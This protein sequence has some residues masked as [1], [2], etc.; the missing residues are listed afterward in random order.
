MPTLVEDKLE[1]PRA[2]S[3]RSK[4]YLNFIA[5]EWLP[6]VSGR[7]FSM[8]N[9][10]DQTMIGQ[11]Q[12]SNIED[13][14]SAIHAANYAFRNSEWRLNSG[15]RAKAMMEAA[16]LLTEQ[17]ETLAP[18]YTIN[19]GKTINEAR[20]ELT[21][22]IDMLQYNAGMTR[23][24]FGRSID[25]AKNAFSVVVREP[26]GV[27]GV[28]SPWNWPVVLMFREMVP[29]LAAGNAIVLKPA[30]LTAAISM[31]V[32]QLFSQV[33]A[34]PKG[35]IN[36]VTGRGQLVGEALAASPMVNMISFTGDTVTG[37]RV[38]ELA[39]TKKVTLELGGKSPNIIFD[40]ADLD[41]AIPASIVAVFLT[42]GQLC[43]AGTRLIVQDTLF[44]ETVRRM[45][46]ATE[47]LKVGNGLDESCRLGP[48]I[49]KDQLERV[50]EYIEIGKNEGTLITGGYRLR[51]PEYDKGFFVAPTIFTDLPNDSRL[52]QEEIFGPVL[53]VQK[54]HSEAEAIELANGTKFGLASAVWTKDVNRA[55]RVARAME[56]GTVWINTYFKIYNQTEF[57]GYKASG[58]GRARGIDGVLEFTQ[59]K[60]INFDINP[61]Y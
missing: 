58:I 46:E 48:L 38:A 57:G 60:H 55:I 14:K 18:L 42:S 47:K 50:M 40:D 15:L 12:Q 44:D 39:A 52:V 22:C 31:D 54:F 29:A 19:N 6:S 56:A 16:T 23:N 49:S 51:G 53:V 43:M 59:T 5:G 32:V 2:T 7:T 33:S 34:F 9:P 1:T 11:A 3:G 10:A 35:I 20:T 4:T 8:I 61:T 25:P 21:G 24:V 41:K 45:K 37:Q 17:K 26:L 36:A 28:I 27:V 30:S 13:M